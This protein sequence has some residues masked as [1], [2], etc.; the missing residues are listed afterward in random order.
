[1]ITLENTQGWDAPEIKK[2]SEIAGA[3]NADEF[4]KKTRLLADSGI[5]YDRLLYKSIHDALETDIGSPERSRL[6]SQ[7]IALASRGLLLTSED[8]SDL[9][10]PAEVQNPAD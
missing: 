5:I 8:L 6:K 10:P 2:L 3:G 4:V 7:L 9:L 1:M